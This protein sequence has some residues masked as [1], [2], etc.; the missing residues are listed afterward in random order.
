MDSVCSSCWR[1]TSHHLTLDT[2]QTIRKFPPASLN[3]C[4]DPW[5]DVSRRALNLLE[6]ILSNYYKCTTSAVT[7]KLN[8]SGYT[9]MPKGC[10]GQGVWHALGEKQCILGFHLVDP[11]GMSSL[12]RPG[13]RWAGNTLTGK[14]LDTGFSLCL[15]HHVT[16]IHWMWWCRLDSSGSGQGLVEGSYGHGKYPSGS[17]KYWEIRE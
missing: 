1:E 16:V 13:S 10:D 6:D 11:Q 8:I 3:G 9:W 15:R 2:S 14:W 4:D 12:G 5:W 17:R 7:H